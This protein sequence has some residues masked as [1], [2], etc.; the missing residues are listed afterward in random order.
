MDSA[1]N[2]AVVP[3]HGKLI[4]ANLIGGYAVDRG[5]RSEGV[6]FVTCVTGF[7]YVETVGS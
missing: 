3:G 2:G 7:D 6:E 4:K 5:S 1:I